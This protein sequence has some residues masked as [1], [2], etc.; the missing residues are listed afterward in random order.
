VQHNTTN[1]RELK[2]SMETTCA[3][4]RVW[5]EL[6]GTPDGK[7]FPIALRKHCLYFPPVCMYLYACICTCVWCMFK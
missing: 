3:P 7:R 1:G 6:L 2:G 4:L 5:V